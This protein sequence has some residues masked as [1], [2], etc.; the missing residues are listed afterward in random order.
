MAQKRALVSVSD[1]TGLVEFVKGLQAAGWQIIAT[2]GTQKLLEESG[3]K[4]IGIS[5][6]T[7]FPEICDGRVKTLHPKVHGA[8]LARRDEP[9]HMAALAENGIELIDL[10]CVNL[11]PFRQTIAKEGTTM[12]EAIEKIDIGGPSMLRS[13]AKNWNDVTVVCDPSDYDR[14]LNEIQAEGNTKKETRLELSA[15][16]YTHTA[17]YDMC[18][19]TYMRKAAGLNE[20][21]FLEYD[22]KQGLRYGENPH[23]DAK[24]YAAQEIVPFS[25]A[26]AKQLHGKELSYNNIQDANAALNIV[27]EFGD[28]PFCVG[29]KHM[30]PCGAAIGKDGV[31]AWKKAY[32]ADTVSI[33]GGI[34]A[35]NCEVNKE[36]AELMKP[37]FLEIIMAPSFSAEALEVLTTKKNLRLLEVDMSPLA[38]KQMQ[39]VSVNGGLLAQ[40]QDTETLLLKADMCVTEAKPTEE[41]MIDLQFAWRIV[42]HVKSNAIVVAK[43][44]RTYGVGAG[45]MNRVGSAE[46][47]LKQAQASLAA[48]GKDIHTAHLVMAS[49]G[50]FPFGDS[51]ESAAE[52]GI[53]AIVQ[54]GGSV[55]DS[56]SIEA[57][58]QHRIPMLFTGMRH[59]KH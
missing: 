3:V 56:E 41:Q 22:L 51:V 15:K 32:E 34:V 4:T 1:K 54:P 20:K 18:I 35:T 10:V 28:T 16:A 39:Y 17:E 38:A 30:N 45:Q 44:G 49:D 26:S 7:G 6:V 2:G 52:Y 53:A 23:Q 29:L 43:D 59:F 33:F 57:A 58:N 55:R 46:I 37:I 24:F 25:L 47:A 31:E 13:A 11:Y 36:M 19:A 12:A 48:E 5:E 14:I 8:L 42:K 9:S 27:R 50:F 21:L 40:H